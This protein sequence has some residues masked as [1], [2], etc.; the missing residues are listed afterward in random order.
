MN[1]M[2]E[3]ASDR[4]EIEYLLPWHA[5]GTLSRRDAERVE[6]ALAS[7]QELARR[8]DLV[9]E[10]LS[11]T[12]HL[13]ESLGAPSARAMEKLF[14]AID[15]EGA[16]KRKPSLALDVRT[17]VAEFFSAFAPRTLAFAGSAAA[18][19]ILL[20]AGVIGG[21][22]LNSPEQATYKSASAEPAVGINFYV[23]FAP[24]VTADEV[25]KFLRDHKATIIDGPRIQGTYQVQFREVATKE[26]TAR[27]LRELQSSRNIIASE[28]EATPAK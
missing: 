10:E 9:R 26:D 28:F 21:M 14:A 22:M 7:D 5:A 27:I 24:K 18:L 19:V 4:E 25:T 16:Y 17:K 15:A 6:R 1:T 3:K 13:N 2:S 23:N 11:E 12:I 20:Q 8:F